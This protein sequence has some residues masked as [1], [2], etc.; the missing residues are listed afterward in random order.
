MTR[1]VIAI[2]GAAAIAAMLAL[3]GSA[4]AGEDVTA[5]DVRVMIVVDLA[6][7]GD[8]GE[9]LADSLRLRLRRHDEY[10]VVDRITTQELT[11]ALPASAPHPKLAELMGRAGATV[12]ICG[13]VSEDDGVVTADVSYLDVTDPDAP[14]S[15]RRSFSD[16]TERAR[17]QIARQIV[18]AIRSEPEWTPPEYGDQV[19]PDNFA[20]PLNANGD[21]A[22]D[23]GWEAPDNVATFIEAG[24]DGRG[25][26][27]RIRTDLAREPWL[28]YRR[29]LRAGQADPA[30][31]PEIATDTSYASL[32]ATDGVHFASEWIAAAPGARYWLTADCRAGSSGAFFPKIFVKGFADAADQADALPQRSMDER[33]LS[34]DD[35]AAMPADQRAELIADDAS[36]HP[37]RYRRER[38]RWYLSC[39]SEADQ[40]SHF[41]APFPPRGGLPEDVD[42]LQIQI[43]CYW[44]AGEYLW[45]NV[46]LYADPDQDVPLPEEPPRTPGRD[47]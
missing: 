45:D 20:T 7:E 8:L 10:D 22:G 41:A 2:T 5:D 26:V 9:Q 40:W 21:F 38:Y 24:P 19:E 13:A 12:A 28:A 14:L 42:W 33:G 37:E 30:E 4:G 27:L 17:G 39:R 3:L 15:W 23:A 34:P 35:F 29:Q 11:D 44:P 47:D 43:Y 6:S 32:A 16:D 46:H 1:P 18:E 31:P 36:E 25:Q